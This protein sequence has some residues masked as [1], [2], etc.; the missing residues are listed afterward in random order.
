MTFLK[1]EEGATSTDIMV[2]CAGCIGLAVAIVTPVASGLGILSTDI[3]WALTCP[4]I[5]EGCTLG[6][7]NFENG[8]ADGWEAANGADTGVTDPNG[9]DEYGQML[10]PYGLD[11]GIETDGSEQ[12][13]QTYELPP[14]T[15]EATVTMDVL[16]VD[17]LDNYDFHGVEEGA[18]F[19]I[20]NQLVA[21]VH[22]S[23]PE[24]NTYEWK[25]ENV[26]GIT[27]AFEEIAIT[28]TVGGVEGW[29]DS[30]YKVTITADDPGSEITV[31]MGVKCNS[32][33][34]DEAVGFDNITVEAS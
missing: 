7:Y 30:I 2:L 15:E 26:E 24:S 10:G 3:N 1:K 27:V 8:D 22:R 33:A 29:A 21:T 17:S 11:S 18:S 4:N 6:T 5:S 32:N 9:F 31:G 14:G 25:I 23:D 20:D 34:E 13:T 16:L 19:Y 12:I 28:E